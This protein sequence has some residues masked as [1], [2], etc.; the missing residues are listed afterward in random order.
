LYSSHTSSIPLARAPAV[1]SNHGFA[2]V[3]PLPSY[4]RNY[5]EI[6]L[7]RETNESPTRPG[8]VILR[9]ALVL[10]E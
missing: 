7:T 6:L 5:K 4:A 2:A 10:K 3:A 8:H 9:G 1:G